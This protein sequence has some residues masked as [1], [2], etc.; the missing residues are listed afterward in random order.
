MHFP[1]WH[2][3]SRPLTSSRMLGIGSVAIGFAF[4]NILQN[5]LAGILL[6]VS[7]PF[8]LGDLISVTGIEGNV[9]D[10]QARA[11]VAWQASERVGRECA[12]VIPCPV[13]QHSKMKNVN[14]WRQRH[15][16]TTPYVIPGYDFTRNPAGFASDVADLNQSPAAILEQST[17]AIQKQKLAAVIRVL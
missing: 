11:T 2:H 3:R 6:L 8:R 1:Q 9:D 16:H 15:R 7:E 5:F 17:A 10:I 4:Q 14:H 13:A 12:Q